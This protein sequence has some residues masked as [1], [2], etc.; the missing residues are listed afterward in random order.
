MHSLTEVVLLTPT[1]LHVLR[2]Y[3]CARHIWYRPILQL[4]VFGLEEIGHVLGLGVWVLGV[5][6]VIRVAVTVSILLRTNVVH[7]VHGTA[8]HAAGLGLIA[9]ESDPK[10]VVRVGREAGASNVLLVTG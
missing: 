5:G 1:M 2:P 8:L 9:S 7:L 10:N 3:R 4:L 6:V